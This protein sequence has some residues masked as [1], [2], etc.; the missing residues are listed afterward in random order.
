[1]LGWLP[2][3]C[4]DADLWIVSIPFA[5]TRRY[6]E[7]VLTYRAIYRARLG[8]TSERV[9]DWLPPIPAAGFFGS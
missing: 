9:S 3:V 5:E 6:V 7:R 8:E 1:V 2:D 4:V